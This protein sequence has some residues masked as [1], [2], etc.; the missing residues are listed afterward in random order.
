MHWLLLSTRR[1]MQAQ[2]T[3]RAKGCRLPAS[4]QE[5]EK[6]PLAVRE[7]DSVIYWAPVS[8]SGLGNQSA[9]DL[10]YF[11]AQLANSF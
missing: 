6:L 1:P 4:P 8:W 9:F 10:S 3:Q 5:F 2:E 11:L 7:T